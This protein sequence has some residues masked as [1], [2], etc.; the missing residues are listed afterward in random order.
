MVSDRENVNRPFGLEHPAVL[1]AFAHDARRG[2]LVLAMYENRPWEGED[3]QLFQLQEKLNAYVSF[4]L[5]G[6]MAEAFPDA[7]GRPVE[8]QLRTLHEPDEKAWGMI[9]QVREQLQ[10]QH[11]G[12]EVVQ[13]AGEGECGTGCGCAH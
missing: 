2:M 6:E 12:F 11:I 13:I 1:D 7:V 8:I 3:R 9:G 5:D 10:L 4:V